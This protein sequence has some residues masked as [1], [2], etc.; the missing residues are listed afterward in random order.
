[1]SR[2]TFT[3]RSNFAFLDAINTALAAMPLQ[4]FTASNL[5][6]RIMGYL[7]TSLKKSRRSGEHMKQQRLAIVGWASAWGLNV[8]KF[9]EEYGCAP[10]SPFAQRQ[11]ASRILELARDGDVIVAANFACLFG[12]PEDAHAVLGSANDNRIHFRALDVD[13]GRLNLEESGWLATVL[14]AVSAAHSS[15]PQELAARENK[16]REAEAGRYRGGR[17]QFGGTPEERAHIGDLRLRQLRGATLRALAEHSKLKGF[18]LS[19][20]GIGKIL[21]RQKAAERVGT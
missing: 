4:E 10:G 3:K 16:K 17:R 6:P 9:F 14:L 15:Y 19:A 11:Q 18:S 1:M 13:S 7:S 21:D 2:R 5:L 20:A 8:D 12:A